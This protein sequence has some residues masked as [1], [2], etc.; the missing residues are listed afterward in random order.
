M[1][2]VNKKRAKRDVFQT[3]IWYKTPSK[4]EAE[5]LIKAS[6]LTQPCQAGQTIQIPLPEQNPGMPIEQTSQPRLARIGHLLSIHRSPPKA[7]WPKHACQLEVNT[8]S[9]KAGPA[10][11]CDQRERCAKHIIRPYHSIQSTS[12]RPTPR[13]VAAFPS[14]GDRS[15]M[16]MTKSS[17]RRAQWLILRRSRFNVSCSVRAKRLPIPTGWVLAYC[18]LYIQYIDTSYRISYS[19]KSSKGRL[20]I[21][22]CIYSI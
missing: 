7:S 5:S 8:E 18:I 13:S 2:Q 11:A 19:I 3:R 15:M 14:G 9:A 17:R 6:R 20:Y 1:H 12:L 16:F 10:P 21:V 22:Y 4:R